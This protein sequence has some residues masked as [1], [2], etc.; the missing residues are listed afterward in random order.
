M[1]MYNIIECYIYTVFDCCTTFSYTCSSCLLMH[2]FADHVVD[3]FLGA[4]FAVD[5]LHVLKSAT[6]SP[7]T[8]STNHACIVT[9]HLMST[10]LLLPYVNHSF[11]CTAIDMWRKECR[12]TGRVNQIQ[13]N[14]INH[15][16]AIT[17]RETSASRI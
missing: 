11:A 12:T 6:T 7:C 17:R 14:T 13:A 4:E 8:A 16:K 1:Y 10:I 2:A 3:C 5:K 9:S 15:G